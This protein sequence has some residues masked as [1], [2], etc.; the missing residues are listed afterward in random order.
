ML[1]LG[2]EVEVFVVSN[3]ILY[4]NFVTIAARGE[5]REHQVRYSAVRWARDNNCDTLWLRC[6][7]RIC[8]DN[9]NFRTALYMRY[10]V[11]ILSRP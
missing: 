5:R 10:T 11:G 6:L 3:A 8:Q 4:G 2:L 1:K 9:S 7:E